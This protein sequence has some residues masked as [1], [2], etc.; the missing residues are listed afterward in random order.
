[1]PFPGA[2]SGPFSNIGAEEVP[3]VVLAAG[4]AS[5]LTHKF[6]TDVLT[7]LRNRLRGRKIEGTHAPRA[8]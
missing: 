2:R 7:M 3:N 6:P 1:M 4:M 8:G 5:L